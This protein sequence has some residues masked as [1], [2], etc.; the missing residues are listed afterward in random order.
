MKIRSRFVAIAPVVAILFLASCGGGSGGGNPSGAADYPGKDIGLPPVADG[1]VRYES[2]PITVP[3]GGDVQWNEWVA[4]PLQGDTDIIEVT[5]RQSNGGHHATLYATTDVQPIGTKRAYANSD[6]LSERFLGAVGAESNTGLTLPSGVVFRAAKGS[7]LLI[8]SHFI[9]AGAQPIQGRSVIDVKMRPADPSARVASIL[10]N[11]TLKYT[12][13]PGQT[14]TV[15]FKC[16]VTADYHVLSVNNHM[17]NLG[18]SVSTELINADGTTTPLKVDPVWE[19]S[20]AFHPEYA[21]FPLQ[22]PLIIPAGST[23][24]TTCTWNNT[25]SKSLTFPDEMCV[26]VG[27]FLGDKDASCVDG[28]WM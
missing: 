6:Q 15:D 12:L 20:W 24:H 9:N 14:T 7:G 26:F 28:T 11:L 18:T 23:L 21:T 5:G 17:H 3:A 22:S 19:A 27:F 8:Q 13:P 16:P 2:T 25:T 10:T 4:A 1:F